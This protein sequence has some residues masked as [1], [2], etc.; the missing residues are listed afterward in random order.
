MPQRLH[1]V[2][3]L[4]LVGRTYQLSLQNMSATGTKRLNLAAAIS[5]GI[6]ARVGDT[7]LLELRSVTRGLSPAVRIMAKAEWFNPSGSIK[8]RP[9]LNI[10]RAAMAKGALGNGKQL[11]DSTSGNMG[12]AYATFGAALGIP[13]TLCVPAS[14]ST[15]RLRVLQA[16]GA[17][18]ILTDAAEGSD[19]AIL[20]ARSLAQADAGRFWYANQY[21]NPANWQAHYMSTGPEVVAQ[22]NGSLTHFVAGVGTSGTLV[23]SGRYLHEQIPEVKIVG[24]QPD[25]AFHGLE[26]LKHMPTAIKPGIYDAAVADLTLGVSTE[27]AHEMVRQLARREG[28]FVGVSSGAA[29]AAALQL[30]SELKEGLLV[31]IFPDAGYKYLSDD[32]LWEGA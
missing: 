14:A 30:A 26:G 32:A 9:A 2:L 20:K 29:A 10:I 27:A 5:S 25:A 18:V 28:L 31:V 23:G 12:I 3:F 15:E 1:S 4:F 11:L 16:L 24:V 21:D 8:D 17:D 7:P 22:T 19:G 6:E 13:V